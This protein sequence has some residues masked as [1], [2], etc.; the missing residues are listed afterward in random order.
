MPSGASRGIGKG[1]ALALAK[2]GCKKVHVARHASAPAA[3]FLTLPPRVCHTGRGLPCR[4]PPCI[5][6]RTLVSSARTPG[7]L[8]EAEASINAAAAAAGNGG[9]C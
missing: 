7:T 6:G 9:S 2:S 5:T 8:A 4:P 1:V 3:R